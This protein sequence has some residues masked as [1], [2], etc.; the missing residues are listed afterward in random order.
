M[1]CIAVINQKGGCG[2]TTVAMNLAACLA[3]QNRRTLLVDMDPQSHCAVGLAVPEEQIEHTIYE[4]LISAHS[5]ASVSLKNIVWQIAPGFDL[6]PAGIEL[7]A[8]EPQLA[9]QDHR[10]DCLR[11]VL[12]HEAND[13]DYVVIDC[14]PSV[15]LLTFN[16]LRAANEVVI[17]VETGYFALH[18]LS[19]QLETIQVL[20]QQCQQEITVKVLASMY[21]VRTKLAREVLSELRKNYSADMFKAII[22]FNTKLKEAASFGQPITEYEPSSKGMKDFMALA[23]EILQNETCGGTV[24]SVESQLMAISKSAIE[25]LA[26]S[27]ILIGS[28][29]APLEHAEMT[30]EEKI[31]SFYGVRQKRD[32]VHFAA[33][34][35][36][37]ER[38]CLA[39]D[40][41]SWQPDSTQL[42][43]AGDNGRWAVEI[44]LSQG[45]YRYRYVVDGRWQQ[46]P[47]N[48]KTVENEFGEY[49]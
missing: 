2:K 32:L 10:E 6:A 1:Q 22:N 44:P 43:P 29:A 23:D 26:E 11:N 40:F 39:G 15:G 45:D 5:D 14:P 3:V 13:Y 7:A 9:G 12:A 48:E 41:N 27:E 36:N 16:S 47:Y 8:L 31:D 18:G 49:N 46:D 4:V 28:K 38:V 20:K 19:R 24:E 21:D 42:N 34:Y 37:A 17:P 25:L 30:I 35:P 33:L